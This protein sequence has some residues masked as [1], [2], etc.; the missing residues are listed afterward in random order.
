MCGLVGLLSST[1]SRSRG[2]LKE[3][4]KAAEAV[5]LRLGTAPQQW[6]QPPENARLTLVTCWPST[7]NTHRLIVVAVPVS[8][9]PL[10]YEAE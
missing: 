3:L 2:W 8:T 4:R 5:Q 10:G 9:Q 6:V 7:S 1:S